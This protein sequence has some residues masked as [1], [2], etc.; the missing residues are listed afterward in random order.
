[1][2]AVS[3]PA[4]LCAPVL[5]PVRGRRRRDDPRRGCRLHDGDAG[6]AADRQLPAAGSVDDDPAS[7]DDLAGLP[8]ARRRDVRQRLRNVIRRSSRRV[9]VAQRDGQS[10]AATA[11]PYLRRRIGRHPD[12][13]PY[14]RRTADRFGFVVGDHCVDP[15]RPVDA[16]D[17]HLPHADQLAADADP[18]RNDAGDRVRVSLFR[19]ASARDRARRTDGDRN[20]DARARGNGLRQPDRQD[21]RRAGVRVASC[22]RRGEQTAA[23]RIEAVARQ[24]RLESADAVSRVDRGRPHHLRRARPECRRAADG[25]RVRGL[26]D[27]TLIAAG[28]VARTLGRQ[29]QPPARACRGRERVR[30]AR[31]APGAGRW[32]PVA[33]P[34]ARRHRV[35]QRDAPI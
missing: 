24:C 27:G 6:R 9:R 28:K 7:R 4:R 31:H 1:M 3:A 11:H 33:R 5:A 29:H 12:L 16:G 15:Q 21:L 23:G 8:V 13:A 18:V 34:R 2:G 19:P 32:P 26:C 10:P 22:D 20:A 30:S 35:R 17:D 14:A 25:T